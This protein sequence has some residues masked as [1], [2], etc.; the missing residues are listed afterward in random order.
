M[1]PPA[2][3]YVRP[4]TVTEAVAALAEGD[5]DAKLIAGGQSLVPLL[6]FRLAS[7]SVLVDLNGV[8]GL[9]RIE[10]DGD[11]L[12][13]GAMTRM[14][15][16]ETDPVVRESLPLLAAAAEWVGHV[17][18]RN[19]GTVG[20]SIAH[21]DPAAEIPAVCL[22]LDGVMTAVG[23]GGARRIAADDFFAGFLMTALADDEV[24]AEVELAIPSDRHRWGFREFAPR[25][26]D[27][28]LA[29]AAVTLV[30]GPGD[31]TESAR[32]VVFGTAERPVR[33]PAAE[34]VLVGQ[35]LTT[36]VMDKAGR[37]AADE[38]LAGDTRPDRAYRNVLT[39]TL[40][41]RALEDAAAQVSLR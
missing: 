36:E 10:R 3:E 34:T 15:R 32:V 6:N 18:I 25:H 17:Q 40:V 29:G 23:P 28:A 22:L 37:A 30:S 16:L 20:G 26:G 24:L 33:S 13:L 27:F 9:D 41:H 4:S 31:A 39:A 21:A 19:R 8:N 2:F 5:G 12:R 7:P 11:R 14:R 1:K 35:P 38:T